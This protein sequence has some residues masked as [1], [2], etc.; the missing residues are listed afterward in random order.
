MFLE[1]RAAD[2]FSSKFVLKV[3]G[4]SLGMFQGRWFSESLDIELTER[5]HLQFR[6]V[7]WLGS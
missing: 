2:C 5:R 1:A 4:R 3:N 6:K 7:G